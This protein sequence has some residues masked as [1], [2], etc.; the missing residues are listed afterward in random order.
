METNTNTNTN[1][2]HQEEKSHGFGH[3]FFLLT[4]FIIGFIV[5]AKAVMWFLK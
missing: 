1:T 3:F 5:L 4:A 2:N